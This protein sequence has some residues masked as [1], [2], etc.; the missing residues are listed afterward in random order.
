MAEAVPQRSFDPRAVDRFLARAARAGDP[1]WLHGEVARRMGERLSIVKRTPER[2]VDW[3]GF[4]GAGGPTLAEVY[5]SARRSVVEPTADLLE[6]SRAALASPWWR[7]SRWRGPSVEALRE[8]AVAPASAGLLWANMML[9]LQADPPATFAAWRRALA[10]DGFLMFSTLGPD[11]LREL[12]D[13][14]QDRRWP[15]PM[16]ALTDMHD[17]GDMLVQAGFADPVMDQETLTL[18]WSD[19]LALL[20]ELRGLGVNADPQRHAALRTPRWRRRL[21]DALAAR[22]RNGRIEL[23]FEIVYGHAF[24]APPRVGVSDRT[25]VGLDDMRR[26]LRR[27]PPG[28]E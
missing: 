14:Y 28:R 2:L 21:A 12:R 23:R 8:Q 20:A 25:E 24:V 16:A 26:M 3:W 1:P 5:P 13:L 7:A 15:S 19:P 4:L 18:H 27:K 9:H 22:A 10:D 11:T 17:L 6:R